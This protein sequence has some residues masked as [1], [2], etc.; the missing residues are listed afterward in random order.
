[1]CTLRVGTMFFK[2]HV[3]DALCECLLGKN[4][5]YSAVLGKSHNDFLNPQTSHSLA[6]EGWGGCCSHTMFMSKFAKLI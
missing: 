1:M 6:Q 4:K 5:A 2:G 3:C